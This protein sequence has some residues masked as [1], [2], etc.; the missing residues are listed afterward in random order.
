M[1]DLNYPRVLFFTS[2]F[3]TIIPVRFKKQSSAT[4]L[5]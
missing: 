4:F 2:V 3:S 5:N 1:V